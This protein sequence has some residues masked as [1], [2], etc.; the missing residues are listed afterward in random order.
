VKAQRD[1]EYER[2][3]VVDESA[4]RRLDAIVRENS[5]EPTYRVKLSDG[6]VLEPS[7]FNEVLSVPNS[8]ARKIREISV[9]SSYKSSLRIELSMN[10]DKWVNTLKFTVRGEEKDVVFVV[11]KLDEWAGEVIQWYGRIAQSA[12]GSVVSGFCYAVGMVLIFGSSWAK[13]SQRGSLI[14]L[15]FGVCLLGLSFARG[16][17]KRW[18]FPTGIFAIGGGVDRLK[19]F[20][21][22]QKVFSVGTIVAA[23]AAVVLGIIANKLS[24]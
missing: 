10:D 16:L 2:S 8:S 20:R 7:D 18:V 12:L 15:F 3:F 1:V 21:A 14:S 17:L 6:T 5:E 19:T 9:D 23:I 24:H 4:L 22:R 13:L 11:A